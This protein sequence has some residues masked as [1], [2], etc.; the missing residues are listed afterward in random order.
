MKLFNFIAIFVALV[1]FFSSCGTVETEPKP[2]PFPKIGEYDI[3]ILD[4]CEYFSYKWAGQDTHVL[5][6]KGN[7]SNPI[8]KCPCK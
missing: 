5:T 2:K 8:H 6:H 4:G 3:M 1:T 7:C